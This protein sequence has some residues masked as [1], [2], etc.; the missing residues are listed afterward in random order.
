MKV[1]KE[2]LAEK[3]SFENP[4]DV[5]D[6]PLWLGEGAF[7]RTEPF[8]R[9]IEAEGHIKRAVIG[10][11]GAIVVASLNYKLAPCLELFHQGH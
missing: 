3:L 11:I 4:E 9:E 6:R 1:G 8:R 10:T 2:R 5:R 7:R